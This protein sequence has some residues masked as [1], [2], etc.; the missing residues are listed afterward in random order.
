[1]DLRIRKEEPR[2]SDFIDS[3]SGFVDPTAFGLVIVPHY[4][5]I[6][7]PLEEPQL[8]ASPKTLALSACPSDL[9][10]GLCA[11]RAARV[12]DRKC[13]LAIQL[14]ILLQQLVLSAKSFRASKQPA[15][16]RLH[17]VTFVGLE[18]LQTTC[19]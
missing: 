15:A 12:C 9:H 13:R 10:F 19:G 14:A 5:P 11:P 16:R 1:V 6:F 8:D 2:A 3:A 18:G 17:T 4:H 7:H